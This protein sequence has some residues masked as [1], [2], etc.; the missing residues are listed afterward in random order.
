MPCRCGMLKVVG[1]ES[2]D[3]EDEVWGRRRP[4]LSQRCGLLAVWRV[5][6]LCLVCP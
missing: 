1:V 6:V 2:R 5:H 4:L 3:E